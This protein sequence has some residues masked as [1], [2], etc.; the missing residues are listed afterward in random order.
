MRKI[1]IVDD[2]AQN[3]YMLEVLLKTHDFEVQSASNGLIALDLARSQTPDMIISDI[4]M[5]SMDGFSLCHACKA[6]ETLRNIPF[7]FYTATYTE[8]KD[9]T[10]AYNLGADRFIVKPVAPDELLN[11]LQEVFENSQNQSQAAPLQNHSKESQYYK[12][13]NEVLISKLED[14]M[15]QLERA[16]KRMTSLYQA[17]CELVTYKSPADLVNSVLQAMVKT[18]GY[19][20]ANFF[21]Y[22]DN[23][24]RFILMDAVGFSAETLTIYRDNLIFKLGEKRGLVGWVAQTRQTVNIPDTSACP[25]WILLDQSILSA[26]FVPVYY[27]EK[28]LGVIGL[29]SKQRG[30]FTSDDE[31]DITALANS[32]AVSIETRKFEEEILQLNARLEQRVAERTAQL[33]ESNHEL[34][35]F[36]YSVSHDLRAPLRSI[37]GFS[38]ILFEDYGEILGEEGHRLIQTIRANTAKMDK[39]ITSLLALSR[40]SKSE[41][42]IVQINMGALVHAVYEEAISPQDRQLF[43]FSVDELAYSYGDPVLLRQV[44]SNL[45]SNAIKYTRPKD[46][47]TI[48]VSCNTENDM[49]V[50][51]IQDSGVGFNPEYA[52]KLFGVF[53]R[54]H[55][56]DQFEGTGV[57]LAIVKRIIQ[58]HGGQVWAESSSEQ[59]AIFSFS[60]PKNKPDLPAP[61]D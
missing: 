20:Q 9:E 41:L 10:F 53:Q 4:L 33:Q 1:L 26:L 18:A 11:L 22:D 15:M 35:A 58:R 34:E 46:E 28:L 42:R 60:L 56:A 12:E 6:D 40:I 2:N 21:T 3:L 8:P 29:S 5:P 45:I 51:H 31:R 32:L 55:Q 17:S 52:N 30:G 61:V 48:R 27:K 44:W 25:D 50:Y 16:N 14:K 49:N 39:L 59:G 7:V 38:R 13:Y 24:E 37:D 54:L 43:T 57:G 47:R 36:S 23:L 19:Q